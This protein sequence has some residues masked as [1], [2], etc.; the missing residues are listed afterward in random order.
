MQLGSHLLHIQA[1]VRNVCAPTCG[2]EL[3]CG[4]LR[5]ISLILCSAWMQLGPLVFC[6]SARLF[7]GRGFPEHHAKGG[8][9]LPPCAWYSRKEANCQVSCAV[10]LS[11]FARTSLKKGNEELSVPYSASPS[12]T[13]ATH[14]GKQVIGSLWGSAAWGRETGFACH[15]PG[16][17]G[18]PGQKSQPSLDLLTSLPLGQNQGGRCPGESLKHFCV[19]SATAGL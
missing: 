14:R 2:T 8:L 13:G 4:L 11:H 1:F 9:V 16:A 3:L 12:D 15:H 5:C 18:N 10:S 6:P 19:K 7:L 17:E